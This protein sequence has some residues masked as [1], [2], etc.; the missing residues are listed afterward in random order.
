MGRGKYGKR[1]S[2]K[3]KTY[4]DW[5]S[6]NLPLL[7]NPVLSQHQVNIA[8]RQFNEITQEYKGVKVGVILTI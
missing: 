4:G 3:S 5:W 7:Y 6:G 8:V 1:S 2:S